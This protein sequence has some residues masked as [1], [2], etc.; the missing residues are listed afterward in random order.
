MK[1]HNSHIPSKLQIDYQMAAVT[2]ATHKK[3][4]SNTSRFSPLARIKKSIPERN[5]KADT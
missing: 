3:L 4:L 2:L 1:Y 5:Q